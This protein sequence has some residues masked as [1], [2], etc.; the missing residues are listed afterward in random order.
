[1]TLDVRKKYFSLLGKKGS[2]GGGVELWMSLF[3]RQNKLA[4]MDASNLLVLKTDQ[5]IWHE[6][7]LYFYYQDLRA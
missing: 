1:M 3:C 4:E 5:L 7:G 6:L 2:K